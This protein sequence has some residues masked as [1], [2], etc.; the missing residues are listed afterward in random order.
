MR[1]LARLLAVLC[2][3]AAAP[4]WAEPIYKWVDEEGVVHYSNARP[5]KS[6]KA[7]VLSEDRV[8][9]IQSEPAATR[10]AAARAETDYLARRIDL[11]ERELAARR[12]AA[13]SEAAD[14]RAMQAAYERCLAD[15]R[16]D[17]DGG[18]GSPYVIYGG[19]IVPARRFLAHN[20]RF[21]PASRITGVTAGNVVTF[22]SPRTSRSFRR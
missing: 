17:C 21:A 13:Q 5:A 7:E 2:S 15:R 22:S 20:R 12:A 3:L 9:T 19:P 1:T 8:S 18:Y 11:L 16:V 6:Q 14:A 10:P 4:V